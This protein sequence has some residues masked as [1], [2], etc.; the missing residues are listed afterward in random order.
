MKVHSVLIVIVTPILVAGFVVSCAPSATEEPTKQPPA[1]EITTEP[2][3]WPT[4]TPEP[5]QVPEPT[6]VS[7]S[8]FNFGRSRDSVSLAPAV[9]ADGES[10]WVTG[11]CLEPLCQFESH[12]T[13]TL[14]F[15][16]LCVI[17]RSRGSKVPKAPLGQDFPGVVISDF[18]SAYSPLDVGKAKRWAHLL[19]D[20]HNLTKC[21]PPPDFPVRVLSS[22]TGSTLP[23]DG[24]GSGGSRRR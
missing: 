17:S 10:F 3:A 4:E 18:Y 9:T 1:K 11:Q 20:S 2:T 24:P 12:S 19:R 15:V 21:K 16:A 14:W 7:T 23:G 22:A 8:T 6:R 13:V 5:T